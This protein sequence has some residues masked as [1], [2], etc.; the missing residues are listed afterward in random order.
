MISIDSKPEITSI[1]DINEVSKRS[2]QFVGAA[3]IAALIN[4]PIN[5]Y[6]GHHPTTLILFIF[7]VFLGVVLLMLKNNYT[8]YTKTLTITGINIFFI[9]LNFADGLRMGNY[10]FFFPL[11]FALP[12]LISSQHKY[13][14]EVLSYF[15]F[16]V[17]CFCICIAFVPNESPWQK[18]KEEQY[19]SSFTIN[20]FCSIIL[21][22]VFSYLGIRFEQKYS[23]ELMEQKGRKELAMKA[24]SQFLSQM[25]H[26][27]RTPM[28]GIL[29]ATNL[30]AKQRVMPG[31]A[32]FFDIL[33]YCSNHMLELINNILDYNKIE[34]GKLDLHTIE[35]NLKHLLQNATLP[36]QNRFDEKHVDLRV[37]IDDCIDEKVLVDEIRMIQILNNL[38]SNALKFTHE[39]YVRLKVSCIEKHQHLL[40]AHFLVED[41][42]IGIDKK[43]F[44]KVFESFE[45]VY[46]ASTREY[47]GTGLG[48]SIAQK[49]LNLMDSKLE[50]ESQPGIG[51]LFSFQIDLIKTD[52][53]KAPILS[54]LV[55]DTDLSGMRI[56]IAEDNMINM[57]VAKKMLQAW[58][59]SLTTAENGIEVLQSLETN[60]DYNLILMDLE[61][62]EMD[63]YTAVREIKKLY[64]SIPVLAY[65]A[66]LIDQ[67]M[68]I[69]LKETGFVDA[70]LKPCQPLELFSKIR[71]YAN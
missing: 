10:L 55:H 59:V 11:L 21:S 34:A 4:F 36:F 24:R 42:G 30:L 52:I 53:D 68:Y 6:L 15:S 44:H 12:F 17:V 20:C 13:N 37:E 51:S 58:N 39:G 1:H 56:L 33:K 62:P 65:T 18:I 54:T 43:D 69:D 48:L 57:L 19:S 71:Q 38:L 5:V 63:G 47:Q 64:P 46:S 23:R 41:T 16:T 25:G 8:R 67:E 45:Q 22:T 35:V 49:L 14:K 29:G 60:A 50:L 7:C 9:L 40:S 66:A 26:E 32:E 31:Q 3:L 28:N 27:L 70:V 2:V 61:M